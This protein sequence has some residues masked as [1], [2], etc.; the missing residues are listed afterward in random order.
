MCIETKTLKI[1]YRPLKPWN[2]SNIAR[3]K[4]IL[5][6]KWSLEEGNQYGTERHRLD[7]GVTT[8]KQL[9][10]W[11]C[12]LCDTHP[13]LEAQ[14]MLL[15]TCGLSHQNFAQT[16][17]CLWFPARRAASLA[18]AGAG[19]HRSSMPRLSGHT[20]TV[21]SSPTR[22]PAQQTG[23][24]GGN[25][26]QPGQQGP[27]ARTSLPS[28]PCMAREPGAEPAVPQRS[29]PSND[30]C[31]Q[32]PFCPG[33][34]CLSH[35]RHVTLLWWESSQAAISKGCLLPEQFIWHTARSL[36]AP[37]LYWGRRLW[38]QAVGLINCPTC[39]KSWHSIGWERVSYSVW[40]SYFKPVVIL[41]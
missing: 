33:V 35:P 8:E 10:I 9:K 12:C 2:H 41:W 15:T 11:V 37:E 3:P 25:R 4:Q 24:Q 18:A 5:P 17:R 27:S 34:I 1:L 36:H 14:G 30:S 29:A 23:L 31:S 40:P 26:L 13:C 20:G 32:P 21:K 22:E 38:E 7:S 6:T 39:H 28:F 19:Q 16:Q